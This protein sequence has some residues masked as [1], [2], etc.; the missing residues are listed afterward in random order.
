MRV[1]Q[2]PVYNS[3]L[4]EQH[5]QQNVAEALAERD[6]VPSAKGAQPDLLLKFSTYTEKKKA[7]YG[8]TNPFYFG[9]FGGWYGLG[10]G[11]WAPM[12]WGWGGFPYMGGGSKY[13]SYSFTKGTL[14]IDAIDARTSELVWC[15]STTGT[16]DN[17]RRVDRK[18]AKSV[19]KIMKRYPLPEG[20][21]LPAKS[22]MPVAS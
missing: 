18:I 7:S 22:E 6:I 15:G 5:I 11:W 2:N 14:V 13:R 4:I 20:T 9:G 10:G 8:Y 17:L 19:R 3:Q 16:V 1:G 12:G 21:R